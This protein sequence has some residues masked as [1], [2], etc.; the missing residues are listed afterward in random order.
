[1]ST[2]NWVQ[3]KKTSEFSLAK[4][5]LSEAS[6]TWAEN[7]FYLGELCEKNKLTNIFLRWYSNKDVRFI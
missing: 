1:M 6:F 5:K 4:L 2:R 3:I 7:K